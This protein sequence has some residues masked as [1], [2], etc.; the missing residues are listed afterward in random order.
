MDQSN[1]TI[2]YAFACT[3]PNPPK[4]PIPQNVLDSNHIPSDTD[5]AQSRTILEQ[6]E[7]Q[8]RTYDGE[9][10]RLQSILDSL[11]L[12]RKE[13]QDRIEKRRGVLSI[14]R[15][16]PTEILSE[17][18]SYCV[19]GNSLY[20]SRWCAFSGA[21]NVS[22]VCS[23]WRKIMIG[24][25]KLWSVIAIDFYKLQRDVKPIMQLC[26]DRSGNH[27][28]KVAFTTCEDES[29][30]LIR[31]ADLDDEIAQRIGDD[32]V[33]A[34]EMLVEHS[35]RFDTLE[36]NVPGR[37]L[38][39]LFDE[40]RPYSYLLDLRSLKVLQVK[41]DAFTGATDSLFWESISESCTSLTNVSLVWLCPQ[42]REM[43]PFKQ[44]TSVDIDNVDSAND[45]L[46]LLEE[47]ERLEHLAV[48][49]GHW[50]RD[51][52]RG[53]I[54]ITHSFLQHLELRNVAI[55]DFPRLF[56]SFTL[57]SITSLT[58]TLEDNQPC[59]LQPILGM[60]ERSSASLQQ[61]R[62]WHIPIR[63][64][65]DL[66][67]ILQASPNLKCLEFK[68]TRSAGELGVT[69]FLSQLTPTNGDAPV[70]ARE[71]TQLHIFIDDTLRRDGEVKSRLLVEESEDMPRM[72]I[73]TRDMN[74]YF[75]VWDYVIEAKLEVRLRRTTDSEYV[76]LDEASGF[77]RFGRLLT[78]LAAV[79]T[80]DPGTVPLRFVSRD[81]SLLALMSASAI[82]D[83]DGLRAHHFLHIRMCHSQPEQPIPRNAFNSNHIPLDLDMAQNKVILE[84]EEEQLRTYDGEIARLQAILDNLKYQRNKVQDRVNKRRALVSILRRVP[85]EIL[86]EIFGYCIAGSYGGHSLYISRR[87]SSTVALNISQVCARWR[88][89]TLGLPKLWSTIGVDLYKLYFGVESIM[90]LYLG[91]SGNHPLKIAFTTLG[92]VLWKL[93]ALSN[94]EQIAERIGEGAVEAVQTLI[95]NHSPRFETLELDIPRHVLRYIFDDYGPPY[96][97]K[98]DMRSLKALRLDE[99]L[100]WPG[101]LGGLGDPAAQTAQERGH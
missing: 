69:G 97:Q 79:G 35:A 50:K 4:Q 33:D 55:A 46:D 68:L 24:L 12:R 25:P 37:V 62:L 23:R 54:S 5:I 71:L 89:I 92:D 70:L 98:L 14:L 7:E 85:M 2:S 53:P 51:L 77:L 83:L 1:A 41:H 27:P 64:L 20:I 75:W 8:I 81:Y 9:I 91:R 86:G 73:V 39:Y 80:W 6:E 101:V 32:A 96:S 3:I 29:E 36:I 84:Q 11:K 57:P 88:S 28:L 40:D 26:L 18:F 42:A 31:F 67:K 99:R 38:D 10:A 82:S 58:V 93:H 49:L 21:L 52:P 45:V 15:R 47:G 72:A 16:F 59:S 19:D 87:C 61:L 63:D 66:T 17:L 30:K 100:P 78:G 60:I 44:F 95:P 43:L 94:M 34:V 90:K 56:S 13:V 74:L 65:S 22:Q 48:R 76:E